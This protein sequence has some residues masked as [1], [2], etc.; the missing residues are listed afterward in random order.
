MF[1]EIV[2]DAF[3]VFPSADHCD[4]VVNRL[5]LATRKSIAFR[6]GGAETR[7]ALSNGIGAD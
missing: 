3:E 5:R 1:K 2:F 6:R 4:S 7:L